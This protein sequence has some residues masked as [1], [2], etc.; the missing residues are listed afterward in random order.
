MYEVI[1][2][3]VHPLVSLD[4]ILREMR[5]AGVS[6]S[7]LLFVD[8][9]PGDAF[10]YYGG[11]AARWCPPGSIARFLSDLIS[12]YPESVRSNEELASWVSRAPDKLVGFGSVRP[13]KPVD[14]I[15]AEVRAMVGL[16]LKGIKLMP[17]FQFF[18]PGDSE[19]LEEIFG[20][21]EKHGLVVVY[22]TGC[23]PGPFENPVVAENA[24]PKHLEGVLDAYPN[25]KLVLAHTGSYSAYEPG[26]WLDEALDL[27]RKYPNVYGDTA[28]VYWYLLS[29]PVAKKVRD[30][31]GFERIVFGSDYPVVAGETMSSALSYVTSS[32]SLSG[33]EKELLLYYNATELLG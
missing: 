1:D 14:E 18:R 5:R 25:L 28:A 15:R 31:V 9:E 10:R 8:I 29:D 20:L 24:R 11:E 3:H 21:A 17:T 27:V 7:V 13:N 30:R 22:H 2:F 6:R 12:Y 23:D 33:R 16:G 19:G 26:I 32:S 4:R